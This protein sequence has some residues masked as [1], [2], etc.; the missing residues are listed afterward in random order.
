LRTSRTR[1]TTPWPTRWGREGRV[2]AVSAGDDKSVQYGSV[3]AFHDLVAIVLPIAGPADITG[4]NCSVL[5]PVTLIETGFP[6]GEA[7]V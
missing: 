5:L 7:A 2:D 1:A 6:T 3:G 4:K